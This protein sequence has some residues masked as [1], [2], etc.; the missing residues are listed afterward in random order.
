MDYNKEVKLLYVQLKYRV[1]STI[2][3]TAV[4]RQLT[5]PHQRLQLAKSKKVLS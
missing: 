5:Q 2:Y 4:Q 3:A 1:K